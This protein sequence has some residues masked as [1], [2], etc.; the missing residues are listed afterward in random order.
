MSQHVTLKALLHVWPPLSSGPFLPVPHGAILN[1]LTSTWSA[2]DIPQSLLIT[3]TN[4]SL[5][6]S[7]PIFLTWMIALSTKA[8]TFICRWE[9]LW[10]SSATSFTATF[11]SNSIKMWPAF[12]FL[13]PVVPT[14]VLLT[15]M[16]FLYISIHSRPSSTLIR[17]ASFLLLPWSILLPA[18]PL[19]LPLAFSPTDNDS[20]GLRLFSFLLLLLATYHPSESLLSLSE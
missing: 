1:A 14:M 13:M 12:V 4:P 20:G 18:P 5:S 15:A 2:G 6:V 7:G 17:M 10:A 16:I 11:P 19:P 3:S 9:P 8:D